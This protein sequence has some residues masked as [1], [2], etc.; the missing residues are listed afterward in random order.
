MKNSKG[1]SSAPRL[2]AIASCVLAAFGVAVAGSLEFAT[3]YAAAPR[4]AHSNRGTAGMRAP[5]PAHRLANRI[6]NRSGA[7]AAS[8]AARPAGTLI[9]GN[10][11]DSGPGS[12]R[13]AVLDAVDGDTIDLASLACSTITLTSGHLFTSASISLVGPGRD[14]LA[15]DGNASGLVMRHEGA[16]LAIS[17]VTITNGR[18]TAGYGGCIWAGG[19]LI[20]VDSAVT[21]C[22]AGDGS[23]SGSF[24]AGLDVLGNL[25]LQSSTVTGNTAHATDNVY[26]GG[27]YV[28][29]NVYVTYGGIV[30]GNT[31]I[32]ASGIARGGGVF[33]NGSATL[34]MQ[35]VIADNRV[36]STDGT[37]YG[38]GVHAN[39]GGVGAVYST[40][41]GNTAHSE[42]Q[43]SY[44]GGIH[45]GDDFGS[46]PGDVILIAS[47][48]SGNTTSASCPDCFIQ[49]GGAHAFGSITAKY[50]TIRDNAVISAEGSDGFARGG[51]VA[52]T[53][54]ETEGEIRLLASTISGNSAIGGT[55]PDGMG[56]GGGAASIQGNFHATNS[57][58]AF[59]SA[60]TLAGGLAASNS[61]NVGTGE[62]QLVSSIV[63]NNQAPSAP[64]IDLNA[65]NSG[66]LV[67]TGD[68]SLVTVASANVT[69]PGDT[70]STDPVLLPLAGN[71]GSTATH[72]LA[73]CSP[74]I[75]TG[76]NPQAL[77]IDQR[78]APYVR[79]SGA[80]ADIGAFELQ[81]DADRIFTDGFDPS[82][83]P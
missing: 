39:G 70:L 52:T 16:E 29:G 49:G 22:V 17:G 55:G 78:M 50:S 5:S 71:G 31:A 62:S 65:Y 25:T 37:A 68:H 6:A 4:A 73:A 72:A 36:E 41:S 54:Y 61:A 67:V 79:E 59:N 11:D 58:I 15:I 77:E 80:A 26:G 81:P 56:Y 63:A 12:L 83:C 34:Y 27:V 21:G 44:G 57:T 38:G 69:L 35:A 40:I 24:G 45:S 60:S 42:T 9:V 48:L 75:D 7:E 20:V 53:A 46:I 13:Q 51:G 43:W 30:S 82:P 19:N 47:N 23:N 1:R 74:A 14:L 76:S 3:A 18:Y 64:D 2:N 33:A 8:N 32:A 66:T 10:C 28:G